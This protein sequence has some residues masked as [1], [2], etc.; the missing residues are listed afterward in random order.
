VLTSTFNFLSHSCVRFTVVALVTFAPIMVFY[1]WH[2]ARNFTKRKLI[3]CRSDALMVLR[4]RHFTIGL[5]DF[6][7]NRLDSFHIYTCASALLIKSDALFIARRTR[8]WV[9]WEL[10]AA[11]H[12]RERRRHV[13]RSSRELG[14]KR[15]LHVAPRLS[16]WKCHFSPVHKVC[17]YFLSAIFCRMYIVKK[18]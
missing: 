18:K 15:L 11:W 5:A 13:H 1:Q 8:R 2:L 3:A 17:L 16:K 12:W 7:E 14:L 9:S 10:R 6:Q 4:V